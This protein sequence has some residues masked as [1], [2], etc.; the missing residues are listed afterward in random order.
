M[1]PLSPAGLAA[2]LEHRFDPRTPVDEHLCGPGEPFAAVYGWGIAG[3]TRKAAAK[4]V[5]GVNA[6][7]ERFPDIPFFTRTA[8][9]AGAKVVRGRLGYS[10]YPGAPDDLLW[11]PVRTAQER[12][13]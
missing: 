7:R 13:A 11:N 2:I 10:P 3:C 1:I 9:P 6:L 12:A 5:V 4:V 8:T